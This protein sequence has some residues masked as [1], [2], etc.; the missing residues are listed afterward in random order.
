MNKKTFALLASLFFLSLVLTGP[1]Q[2]KK[3]KPSYI[4]TIAQ[5]LENERTNSPPARIEALEK[6]VA[7]LKNH[8]D[9]LDKFFDQLT[10]TQLHRIQELENRV[11][12][13]EARADK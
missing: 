9:D 13:L 12:A 2:S 5:V 6:Q 4:D 10:T 3:E 8:S 7:K 11:R 1:A